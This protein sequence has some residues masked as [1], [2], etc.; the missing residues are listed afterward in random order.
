MVPLSNPRKGDLTLVRTEPSE[1]ALLTVCQEG[2]PQEVAFPL[3]IDS[4]LKAESRKEKIWL[5]K[6]TRRGGVCMNVHH[7]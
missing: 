5:S 1:L 2:Q 7:L 4:S 6:S 3:D